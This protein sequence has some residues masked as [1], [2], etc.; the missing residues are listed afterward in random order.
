MAADLPMRE[1]RIYKE[2]EIMYYVHIV[3]KG[4]SWQD[5]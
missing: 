2:Q 4:K 5:S 3:E 1:A